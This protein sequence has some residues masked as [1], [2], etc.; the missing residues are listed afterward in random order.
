MSGKVC[1]VMTGA[2]IMLAM[3]DRDNAAQSTI[4]DLTEWFEEQYTER[5]GGSDCSDII[6]ANPLLKVER[7][8]EI[9][10]DTFE[11]ARENFK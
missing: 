10:R 7:C 4:P 11:K 2:V 8:P 5:Y 3:I 1:G 9:M 6:G